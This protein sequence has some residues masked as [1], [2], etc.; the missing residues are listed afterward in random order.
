MK[1]YVVPI[2][3]CEKDVCPYFHKECRFNAEAICKHPKAIKYEPGT[4]CYLS[5]EI[6]ELG[7]ICNGFP[8][9]CPLDE[10]VSGKEGEGI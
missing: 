6:R 2:N 7:F 5:T 9:N 10:F 1:A 3:E 4:N 8:I